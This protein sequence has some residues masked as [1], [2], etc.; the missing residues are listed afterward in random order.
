MRAGRVRV[1]VAA[2]AA[3]VLVGGAPA[4]AAPPSVPGAPSAPARSGPELSEPKGDLAAS[5]SCNGPLRGAARDPILLVPGTTL[6]PEVNFGWNYQRAFDALGWRWCAVTLPFDATGDIQV[7]GEYVVHAVRTMAKE[8]RRDVD[9]V[10]YSQGG[11]V[12][13]WALRWW[14]DT[15][16][17]VD[18]V[19]GLSPSNHGTVVADAACAAADCTPANHQQASQSRFLAALNSGAETFAGIDYTVAYTVADEIVVPNTPPAPSSALYTGEGTIANIALQEVCPA[20]A[21]DHF[22]IGSYDPVGYAIVV[23]ALEHDGPAERS[24]ISPLTC[25]RLFQPGVDPATFAADYTAMV[26]YAGNSEGD[27]AEVPDEP[28]LAPY[29]RE[30]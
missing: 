30:R 13:R 25:A 29:V 2:V 14:P 21:A 23:D 22:A 3:L 7:A 24:R 18:D 1:V 27:A 11:M 16:A 28:P 8:S 4:S 17:L 15:R 10:G 20:N 19:V 9:V 6:T 26:R 12:P 5:L